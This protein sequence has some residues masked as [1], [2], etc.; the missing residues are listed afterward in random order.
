VWYTRTMNKQRFCPRGHDTGATGR[1][2]S[3]RCTLCTK[4][5]ARRREVEGRCPPL[6]AAS[7][8]SAREREK[9]WKLAHPDKVRA[10]KKAYREKPNSKKLARAYNRTPERRAK[11]TTANRNW[12]A[13]NR[14]HANQLC[15]A[16]AYK[17]PPLK[18]WESDLLL[19][20]YGN[21][22]VYCLGQ[23]TG[24]DH[25][26][27][28]SKGGEHHITNLAPACGPCNSRKSNHPIWVMVGKEGR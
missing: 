4:S 17:A 11:A 13:K 12:R 10:Y 8:Q 5:D 16:R 2:F 25:L 3:G 19:L 7:K 23:A 24:F 9:V 22:C 1:Y 28:I 27:P 18:K 6:S 26:Y 21:S 14:A 15:L 20:Y